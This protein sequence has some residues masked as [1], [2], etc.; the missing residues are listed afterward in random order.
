VGW[1]GNEAVST[2]RTDGQRESGSRGHDR[3]Q[4]SLPWDTSRK[5]TPRS[6]PM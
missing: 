2:R 3:W 4:I 1:I 5:P 6:V